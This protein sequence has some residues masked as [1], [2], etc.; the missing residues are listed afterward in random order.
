VSNG[1]QPAPEP[2]GTMRFAPLSAGPCA[3]LPARS[4][5]DGVRPPFACALGSGAGGSCVRRALSPS[6]TASLPRL[7]LGR[8]PTETS[9]SG[10]MDTLP[11]ARR[12]TRSER[13]GLNGARAPA[14]LPR[15]LRVTIIISPVRLAVPVCHCH[16]RATRF[17]LR[18]SHLR[19]L[20]T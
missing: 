16:A 6:P 15:R 7:G 11:Y 10:G 17:G 1:I 18:C 8:V 2:T 14:P 5:L 12:T 9:A 13:G 4:C 20:L 19:D 3:V